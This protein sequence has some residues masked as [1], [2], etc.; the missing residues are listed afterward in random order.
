MATLFDRKC[1]LVVGR[2]PVSSTDAVT[3]DA[4]VIENL[5]VDFSIEKDDKPQPNK[6]EISVYNLTPEHRGQLTGKGIKVILSAGYAE[7]I[8][9]VFS[10]DARFINSDKKGPDWITK[11]ECGDA[12]RAYANARVSE[13]F[14]KGTTMKNVLSSLMG[15][16]KKFGI[17]PGNS[18]KV[19]TEITRNFPNGHVAHGLASTELTR[20][21]TPAGYDWSFQDGR[22]E[23]LQ[24]TQTV[25][26][27]VPFISART[28]M[29]GSPEFGT[30]EKLKGPAFLKVRTLLMPGIRPGQKFTIESKQQNGDFKCR[31]V[32]YTASTHGGDWYC[33]IEAIKI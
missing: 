3:A 9:Q 27:E 24:Q 29:I 2:Q 5:R 31:K 10:G 20:I 6:C 8:A 12:E 18:D 14:G 7:T 17:D 25:T 28:G 23:I 32:K 16:F 30:G 21:L 33:D 22:V 15:S 1:Q 11:F 19:S 26:D 13:S 4:M